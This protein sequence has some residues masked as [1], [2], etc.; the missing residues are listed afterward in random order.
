[1][2]AW[3][4]VVI[5]FA[6]AGLASGAHAQDQYGCSASDPDLRIIAC[7]ALIEAGAGATS[8]FS[9][10]FNNRGIGYAAKGELDQAILDYNQAI[11]LNERFAFAYSNRGVAY[12]AKGDILRAIEDYSKAIALQPDLRAAFNNRCYALAQIGKTAQALS[13]CNKSLALQSADARALDSRGYVYFRSGRYAEAID[14]LNAAIRIDPSMPTAFYLRGM[15]KLIM[16]DG[17][18]QDDLARARTL[19]KTIAEKMAR[20]GIAPQQAASATR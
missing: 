2:K 15:A 5:A 10:V 11:Y 9:M 8:D 13:D 4:C 1:M 16:G 20:L 7:S 12:E 18:S 3:N 17:S 6:A 14:D 19:D